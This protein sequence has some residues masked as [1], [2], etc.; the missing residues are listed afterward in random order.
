LEQEAGAP[1]HKSTEKTGEIRKAGQEPNTDRPKSLPEHHS[2]KAR[3]V[4]SDHQH[5][6]QRR[7]TNGILQ[8]VGL[9]I[10]QYGFELRDHL[11]TSS[12]SVLRS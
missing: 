4:Q 11:E 12:T 5:H 6:H 8:Q 1:R 7:H 2:N 9:G 3:K 10:A